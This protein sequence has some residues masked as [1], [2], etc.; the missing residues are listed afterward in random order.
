MQIII[1]KLDL[2]KKLT[3][4]LVLSIFLI[5]PSYGSNSPD[6]LEYQGNTLFKN[7]QGIRIVFFV[8]VYEGS[9]YLKTKS[10]NAKEILSMN[11][12]MAIRLDVISSMVTADAMKKALNDGLEKSTGNNKDSLND[13]IIQL[14]SSFNTLVNPGDYYEFIYIPELGTHFMKNS[15]LVEILNFS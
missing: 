9:L 11:S 2:K 7:G 15:E 1:M 12:P 13:E 3:A 5:M 6:Q 4:F 10:S 8:K 14:S